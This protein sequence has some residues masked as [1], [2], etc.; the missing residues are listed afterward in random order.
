[1]FDDGNINWL[2]SVCSTLVSQQTF[3]YALHTNTRSTAI[4]RTTTTKS[5]S[6]SVRRYRTMD[7]DDE[8][9][10]IERARKRVTVRLIIDANRLRGGCVHAAR[11]QS[12][13]QKGFFFYLSLSLSFNNN[14]T[15]TLNLL[16]FVCLCSSISNIC[17]CYVL[18]HKANSV[19]HSFKVW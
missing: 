17:Y 9:R 4:A 1:M 15:F 11:G 13:R 8:W 18:A 3:T 14:I 7:D 10:A 5:T 19:G 16:R 12:L 6:T 2:H